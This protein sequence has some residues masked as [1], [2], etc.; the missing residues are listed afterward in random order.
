MGETLRVIKEVVVEEGEIE[1]F[2]A[3]LWGVCLI[4]AGLGGMELLGTEEGKRMVEEVWDR[5][6]SVS[7][8]AD[9][10]EVVLTKFFNT[11]V[12]AKAAG[13]D[14][15]M[16]GGMKSIW[17][18]MMNKKVK[19]AFVRNKKMDNFSFHVNKMLLKAGVQE[20][21]VRFHSPFMEDN[22]TIGGGGYSTLSIQFAFPEEVRGDEERSDDRILLQ[23]NN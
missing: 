16:K 23:Y 15:E 11:M 10:P 21:W 2:G 22:G 19:N 8:D 13:L 20:T 17:T 9:V 14:L 3:F 12:V 1:D 18:E 4:N 5:M 7:L 6:P